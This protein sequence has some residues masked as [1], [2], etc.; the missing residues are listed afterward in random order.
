MTISFSNATGARERH[1]RRKHLNPLFADGTSI[2]PESVREARSQDRADAETF[3]QE[4]PKLVEEAVALPPLAD[5]DVILS[6][7]ER[8]DKAYEQACGLSGDQSRPKQAI[9]RL[10]AVI[11]QAVRKGAAGDP[12]AHRELEQEE[13]AREAHFTLLEYPLIADLLNPRSPIG[14][15]E[16][17]PTL[18]S[19]TETSLQAA[20]QLFDDAQLQLLYRDARELLERSP[21]QIAAAHHGAA[22]LKTIERVLESRVAANLH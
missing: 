10:L 20:L 2:N 1:L 17:A 22:R 5:S 6:L 14:P 15:R 8:L 19:E 7:K 18:L 3:E 13:L 12:Q 11:M 21:K 4:F 16:L 9:R